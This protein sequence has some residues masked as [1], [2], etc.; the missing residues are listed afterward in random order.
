MREICYVTERG[1]VVDIRDKK[2]AKWARW[3]GI[4][5]IFAVVGSGLSLFGGKKAD[6]AKL[7]LEIA[8]EHGIDGKMKDGRW[9][10]VKMT[11][12]NPGDDVSGDLTVRMAGDGGRTVVYAKHV[13]LPKQSTK[14]VWFTLPGKALNANNNIVEFYDQ[15]VDKGDLIPFVQGKVTIDT[16]P[17][18]SDTLLV[19]VLARDPDTLNFLSLLNQRGYPVQLAPLA[20]GDFPW[21][22]AMLDALDVIAFNDAPT[23]A[24]KPEQVK[25]IQAWV[26]RGG[27]LVLGGGAGYAKTASAFGA[28]SPVTVAGTATVSALTEFV[29]STGKELALTAPFT[30]SKGAVKSGET[31]FSE[32][33]IP[34]VVASPQGQG[35]VTYVAYDLALQPLA[36]WSGNAAIWERILFGSVSPS[37]G[38]I[39]VG[40]QDGQ[41]ELNNALEVFPQLIPPAYGILTL[42]FLAYAILVAP[43]MY[44]VLKKMDRREWAWFAI[45]SVAIVTSLIIY[46]IGASGR[47]STLAQT[48]SVNELSGTGTASRMSASSVF[49]PSGGSYELEWNGKRNISPIMIND[50]R[51]LQAGDAEMIIRSE[52]DKTVAS[53]EHVPFWSVRKAFAAQEALNEVGKFDYTIKFDASGAK[54]EVVN[55]TNNELYEAGVV[56]GGQWYRLGDMKPGEKKQFQASLGGSVGMKD[57][58]WGN[59]IFPYSGSQDMMQRE[60]SLLNSFSRSNWNG[61]IN[62]QRLEPYILG[63]SKSSGNLFKIDGKDVQSERIDL[64]VQQMKPDYAQDG[65]VFVPAGVIVPYTESSNVTH[66]SSYYNGGV[67]MGSGDMTLVYRLPD[68][69]DWQYSKVTLAMAVQQQFKIELWNEK[70]QSWGALQGAQAELNADQVKEALT[71]GNGIRLKV[72]NSQNNGRFTYPA[73]SAEGAVKKQ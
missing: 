7:P 37:A 58:Q 56:F 5:L 57:P 60:R 68:R 62:G 53:F 20:I 43:A 9:F 27:K 48:L 16:R 44:V 11:I 29:Q 42:L 4:L 35:A 19:G 38:G 33:G 51:Q 52:P 10:P 3:I 14:I 6:A 63:F 46:G 8:I 45:P 32:N 34:L 21:D 17:V 61:Q 36:S 22:S 49:V 70:S 23:D 15:S 25:E 72:T 55:N 12:T 64:F 47:G 28:I 67:E 26:E 13:D 65:R 18:S 41:W 1:T 31:L 54:G 59:L 40:Q 24:L 66:M 73:L 50:G 30:V 69:A 39:R 71:G 2:R